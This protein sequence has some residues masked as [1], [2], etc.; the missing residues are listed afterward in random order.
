[1]SLLHLCNKTKLRGHLH[2]EIELNFENFNT[3][4]KF[5]YFFF[6]YFIAGLQ[7]FKPISELVWKL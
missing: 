7:I 1:M 3:N 5:Q 2:S 6:V 4:I